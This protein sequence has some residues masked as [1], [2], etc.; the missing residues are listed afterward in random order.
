[1]GRVRGGWKTALEPEEVL[2]A[3]RQFFENQVDWFIDEDNNCFIHAGFDRFLPFEQQQRPSIYYWDRSLWQ[4]AL[5]WLAGHLYNPGGEA[6]Y[7]KT[8]FTDIFLGHTATMNWK[9]DKP[10][11][12]AHIYNLDTGAG[13]YGRLTIMD[14]ATKKFWQSDPVTDVT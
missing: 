1:M 2:A 7:V 8:A 13:G 3:H 12:A 14:V 6:F 9:K 5:A 11:K 4:E 10:M